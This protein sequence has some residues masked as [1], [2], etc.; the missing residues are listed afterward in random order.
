M[1]LDAFG[2]LPAA[3]R[4]AGCA[5]DKVGN[6]D[7][8]FGI[9]AYRHALGIIHG[10]VYEGVAIAAVAGRLGRVPVII[11]EETRDPVRRS[12]AEFVKDTVYAMRQQVQSRPAVICPSQWSP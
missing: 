12:A 1:C 9:T 5:V 8:I 11:G 10:A 6:G 4:S 3:L 7:S 2:S